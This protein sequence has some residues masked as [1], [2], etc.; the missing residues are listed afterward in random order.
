MNKLKYY[1]ICGNILMLA[2][3]ITA[4]LQRH[5]QSDIPWPT[6]ADMQRWHVEDSLKFNQLKKDASHDVDYIIPE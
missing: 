6:E 5:H 3:I 2:A 1:L 4:L